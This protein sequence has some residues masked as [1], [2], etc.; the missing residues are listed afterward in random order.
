MR[1]AKGGHLA[2]LKWALARGCEWGEETCAAAAEGG[3]HDVIQ[4][5]TAQGCAWDRTTCWSAARQGNLGI[6]QWA[7]DNGCTCDIRVCTEA[8]ENGHTNVLQWVHARDPEVCKNPSVCE[9]A[10]REDTS[11]R[12]NGPGETKYLG[13]S[14][15]LLCSRTGN[16][17]MLMWAKENGC[18]YSQYLCLTRVRHLVAVPSEVL[19]ISRG[20]GSIVRSRR[21]EWRKC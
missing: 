5:L 20:L 19:F 15:V 9:Y 18:P 16:L 3:H 12:Y 4:W 8:A 13:M 11:K 21:R 17:E 14:N 2:E 10:A 1:A 7:L 6:L